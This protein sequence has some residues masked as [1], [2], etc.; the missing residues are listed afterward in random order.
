MSHEIRTPLTS[1]IGFADLLHE[2]ITGRLDRFVEMISRSGRRLVNTVDTVL[3]LSRL[4]AEGEEL[5]QEPV[6][7]ASVVEETGRM[8]QHDA[9][10]KSITFRVRAEKI[11]GKV[12]EFSTRH[13][14]ENLIQNAIKFTP[15]GGQVEVRTYEENGEAVLEVEDTGIGMSED[16][17]SEVFEAFRQESEGKERDYEGTGLGLA[18]VEELTDMEGGTIE[19]D[20]EKGVGS[21]FTVRFPLSGETDSE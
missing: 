17:V 9:E 20:T 16:S 18:L 11:D 10:E 3:K 21:R 2:Q 7:I 1:I 14:T 6:Q 8:L 12:N 5:D 19:V 13:I 4:Q 15:E